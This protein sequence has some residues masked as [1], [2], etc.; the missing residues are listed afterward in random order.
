MAVVPPGSVAA[1]ADLDGAP[2]VRVAVPGTAA[3]AARAAGT[4]RFE[5]CPAYD[6]HDVWFRGALPELSGEGP[7]VLSFGGL[8]YTVQPATT[9]AAHDETASNGTEYFLSGLDFGVAPARGTRETRLAVW[10]LTNTASLNGATPAVT[11]T[12]V[13]INTELYAQPPNATQ[14]KG[15]TPLADAV[16]EPLELLSANEDRLQQVVFAA[17]RLCRLCGRHRPA[18]FHAGP[19]R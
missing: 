18:T 4:F 1:P 8:A 9:P 5:T 16:H 3:S 17:G 10:A 12:N 2:F 15:P 19:R 6:R 11:L 14:K 13:V 7:R